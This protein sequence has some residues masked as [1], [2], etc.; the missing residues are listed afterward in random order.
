MKYIR[1]ILGFIIA[2]LVPA[3]GMCVLGHT[4]L[5]FGQTPPPVKLD[6]VI[7]EFLSALPIAYVMTLPFAIPIY[8]IL[9]KRRKQS[10]LLYTEIGLLSG[11][12]LSSPIA[13]LQPEVNDVIGTI[14]VITV[15]ALATTILFCLIAVSHV[16]R[17]AE[18]TPG[19]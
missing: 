14:A 18:R 15:T 5:H 19:A 4:Y 8:F 10:L 11:L 12:V 6:Y 9:E 17:R 2:P 1:P 3:I 16:T 13:L 7:Y